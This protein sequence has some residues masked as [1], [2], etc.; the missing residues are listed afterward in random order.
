MPTEWS[1]LDK[2]RPVQTDTINSESSFFL[3]PAV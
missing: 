1:I 3:L 2:I